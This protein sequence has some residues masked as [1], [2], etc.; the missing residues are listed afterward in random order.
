MRRRVATGSRPIPNAIVEKNQPSLSVGV[1][2]R[3]LAISR[4]SFYDTP[5]GETEMNLDLMLLIDKQ[6]PDTP[7][8]G[9]RQ[10][11]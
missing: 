5:Q 8:C 9:V 3:L 10:M 7:F 4:S 2:C 6:F 11:T 1:Q